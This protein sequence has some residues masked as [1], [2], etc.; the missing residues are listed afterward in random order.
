MVI[1]MRIEYYINIMM[2]NIDWGALNVPF[3]SMEEITS[4]HDIDEM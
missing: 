3:V 4:E 1:K 2:E